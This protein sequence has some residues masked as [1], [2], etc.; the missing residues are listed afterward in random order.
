M[1]MDDE[2]ANPLLYL[3]PSPKHHAHIPPH[4]LDLSAGMSNGVLPSSALWCTPKCSF[5]TSILDSP[6][7]PYFNVINGKIAVGH[8][9]VVIQ[10]SLSCTHIKNCRQVSAA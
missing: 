3:C 9:A 4:L 7:P 5:C 8:A 1:L 2:S 6:P 10:S